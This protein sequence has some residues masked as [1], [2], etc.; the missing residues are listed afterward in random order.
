MELFYC[1]KVTR[2]VILCYKKLS[3]KTHSEYLGA[4]IL[5]YTVSSYP[6]LTEYEQKVRKNKYNSRVVEH[7]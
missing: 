2:A 3:F 6:I 5:F 7:L 4:Y 1:K